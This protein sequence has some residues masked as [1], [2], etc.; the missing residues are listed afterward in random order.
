MSHTR[1]DWLS[2]AASAAFGASPASAKAGDPGS[3]YTESS[4]APTRAT[5]RAGTEPDDPPR[6]AVFDSAD[7]IACCR[8]KRPNAPPSA[9]ASERRPRSGPEDASM[10]GLESGDGMAFI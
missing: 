4:R 3:P 6:G 9:S 7:S 5:E 10:N 1:S 8:I 2:D